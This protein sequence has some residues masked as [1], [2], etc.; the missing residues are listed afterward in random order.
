M[1]SNTRFVP[2]YLL[3]DQFLIC[4]YRHSQSLSLVVCASASHIATI[5]MF[6]LFGPLRLLIR[7]SRRVHIPFSD[8]PPILNPSLHPLSLTS[9]ELAIDRPPLVTTLLLRPR[10]RGRVRLRY[11]NHRRSFTNRGHIVTFNQVRTR[12]T[13][14]SIIINT[15]S[16]G[17]YL[18]P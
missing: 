15:I 1:S 12:S 14:H 13:P 8:F 5:S 7:I 16:A 17:A 2:S 3:L 4:V 9:T 11:T 10:Q 18:R 6:H